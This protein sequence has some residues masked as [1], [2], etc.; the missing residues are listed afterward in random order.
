MVGS[1]PLGAKQRDVLAGQLQQVRLF[2]G[3]WLVGNDD[4]DA[5][6]VCLHDHLRK[7]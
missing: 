1:Q 6:G 7:E 4:E 3:F 2:A 5:A